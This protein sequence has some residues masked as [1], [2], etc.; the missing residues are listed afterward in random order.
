MTDAT[1]AGEETLARV[2]ERN[3]H[4]LLA[5][6]REEQRRQTRQEKTAEWIG[7][8]AGS[9]AF[10]YLHLAL[11]GAWVL[12][13]VGVLPVPR[14]DPDFVKLA[15]FASVEAIFVSTFVLLTQ[16]RMAALA[17]RRAE[18][19]LQISLLAEHEVTRLMRLVDGIAARMGVPGSESPELR[20]LKEDVDPG[21]VLDRLE[22]TERAEEHRPGGEGR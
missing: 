10:V 19:A 16:N 13:N 21:R 4:A 12:L 2:V 15:T 22:K 18:L 5:R 17:E 6:R 9:M 1:P 8:F 3:I 20:E 14:F 7:R 11:F